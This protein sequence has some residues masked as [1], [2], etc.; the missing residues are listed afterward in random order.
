MSGNP[1]TSLLHLL[2]L[3]LSL[4]SSHCLLAIG[5]KLRTP[6]VSTTHVCASSRYLR[7]RQP[8]RFL[9]S[10]SSSRTARKTKWCDDRSGELEKRER[11]GGRDR[12]E[13]T[14]KG[15]GRREGGGGG[16]RRKDSG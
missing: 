11:L 12:N 2:Q 15:D 14:R 9:L 16:G 7:A 4:P 13:P 3:L 8:L 5:R 10:S 6:G 1:C